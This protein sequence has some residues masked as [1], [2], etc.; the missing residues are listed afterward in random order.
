MNFYKRHIGDY[1]KDAGHLSLLEHGVYARL[2]DVYYT[3]ESGIPDD[4]ACELLRAKTKTEISAVK[5]V[6]QNFFSLSDGIWI[7]KRCE[8]EIGNAS[9]KAEKNR[10]NGQK[11]GRPQKNASNAESEN[12]P[13]GYQEKNHVGSKNNLS[14]TPDTRLQTPDLNP[15]SDHPTTAQPEQVPQTEPG[16]VVTAA[17]KITIAM[18]RFGINADPG[19]SLIQAVAKQGIEPETVTAACAEAKRSKPNEAISPAYIVGILERWA[20]EAAA[21]NVKGAA[22]PR[23]SPRQALQANAQK[24]TDRIQAKTRHEPDDTI[25][26]LN[27]RPA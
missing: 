14:Q 27:E 9:A 20:R 7:Q 5:K 25:I 22:Q 2:M 18:R 17:G 1:L 16:A 11:G 3:R 4:Q 8:D 12:N 21:L 10:L 6:L 23:A 13:D 15:D 24:L 26:D 19:S